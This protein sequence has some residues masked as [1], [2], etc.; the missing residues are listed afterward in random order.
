MAN[1]ETKGTCEEY[2]AMTEV[3]IDYDRVSVPLDRYDE[4]V[5]AEAKL[6]ILRSAY[7][8]NATCYDLDKYMPLIF[9]PR[10]QDDSDA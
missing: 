5:H 6:E 7:D 3:H 4:L 10:K 2:K 8:R 1:T 9:G